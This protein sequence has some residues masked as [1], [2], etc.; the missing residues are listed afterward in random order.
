MTKT[1][2]KKDFDQLMAKVEMVDHRVKEYLEGARYGK[3]SRVH[4][5]VNRGR[6]MTSNIA[7]CINNCLDSSLY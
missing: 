7:E 5:T 6:M 3:W 4:L 1:Y 2:R